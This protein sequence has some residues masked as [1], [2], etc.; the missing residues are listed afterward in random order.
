MLSQLALALA[1]I[2]T[3]AL[4]ED[5][6]ADC[7]D[8][9][10]GGGDT[11][12]RLDIMR[13]S[14]I[15]AY[16]TAAIALTFLLRWTALTSLAIVAPFAALAVTATVARAPMALAMVYMPQT[17][18]DGLAASVGTPLPTHAHISALIAVVVAFL[19]LGWSAIAVLAITA[20]VAM[21]FLAIAYKKIGGI[22][23]D[24]LGGCE[25]I[26]EIAILCT[27]AAGGILRTRLKP[28]VSVGTMI[29][30]ACW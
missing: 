25:Q 15:G 23:G 27:L 8:G 4:H 22:T 13:D 14:R 3:G 20:L 18:R 6:L 5:G 30:L 24:V 7:A 11:A 21:G 12:R 19:F 29:M 1:T 9:F 10:W 28:G 16:G 17:R 26:S 2:L